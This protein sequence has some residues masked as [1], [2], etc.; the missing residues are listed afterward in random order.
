MQCVE[1]SVNRYIPKYLYVVNDNVVLHYLTRDVTNFGRK[2]THNFINA[3]TKIAKKVKCEVVNL[4][5]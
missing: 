1:A 3:S 5:Y 2:K 4:F